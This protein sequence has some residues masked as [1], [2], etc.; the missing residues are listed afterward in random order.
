PDGSLVVVENV[1]VALQLAVELLGDLGHA[2][3]LDQGEHRRLD[4]SQTR[5][6]LEE[7]ALLRLAILVRR[8]VHLVGFTQK[9]QRGPVSPRRGLDHVRNIA[10]ARHLV[11]VAE[12]LTAALVLRLTVGGGF[13]HELAVLVDELAFHVAAQIEVAAMGDTFQF[14]E[15]PRR[16]ERKGIF[17]VRGARGV[18]TQLFL[19]MLAQPQ[20]LTGQAEIEIPL[21]TPIAPVAIPGGRLL[22]LAEELDLHLLELA[23]AEGEVARRDLVAEA[24]ADLRNPER[25][26]NARAVGDVLEVDEDPLR[27]L[28]PQERRPLLAAQGADVGLEHQVELARLG[29]RA[30]LLRIRPEDLREVLDRRQPD[31]LAL[32]LQ[33]LDVLGPQVEELERPLLRLLEP[34]LALLGDRDEDALPFRLDPAAPDL[35]VAVALL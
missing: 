6:Q 7:H 27:R 11:E 24:L 18:V 2:V 4:G 23:R 32:P 26:A 21:V 29:Q 16:Q 5:M 25:D 22:G 10:L 20:L 13:Q 8:R 28:G 12:V 30:D 9:R 33:L 31:Q 19:V 15:L 3:L 14:A 34:I 17:D 1:P 35:V